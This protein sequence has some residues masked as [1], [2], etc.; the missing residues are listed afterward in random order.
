MKTRIIH[1]KFWKDNYISTLN[2]KE[3]LLFIYLITN[4]QVSICGIYELPDKYIRADLNL[5]KK[6]LTDIKAKLQKDGKIA[7]WNGWVRVRNVD[8]YNRYSGEKNDIARDREL[9]LAPDKLVNFGWGIDTSINTSMDTLRNQKSE[10]RN[11]KLKRKGG[12]GGK[13]DLDEETISD[14]QAKFPNVDVSSEL[15]SARDWLASTGKHY[16]DYLAFFRNWLRRS[17]RDKTA[18]RGGVV[19]HHE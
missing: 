11:Q 12:V 8:K 7:F 3:K 10:I 14:L 9:S 19:V 17:T 2:H 18:K 5:T 15:D 16:K 6:E 4:D 1:T 13:L